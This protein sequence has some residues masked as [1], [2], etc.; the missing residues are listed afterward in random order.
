MIEPPADW[1][2]THY[3]PY[4]RT[5]IAQNHHFVV[6]PAPGV[7][8]ESLK[9][10]LEN[11]VP[12]ENITVYL[13][14][15]QEKYLLPDLEYFTSQGGRIKV[16]GLTTADRDAAMTRDSDYDILKFMTVEESKIFYGKAYY[17]RISNTEK[18]ERRRKGLLLHYN[19]A[20]DAQPLE[21]SAESE[22]VV[23]GL[24][25][26]VR[27]KTAIW[28]SAVTSLKNLTKKRDGL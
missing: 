11:G 24:P 26:E 14:H 23:V 1:L 20:F 28:A 16:E 17:P 5:A 4:F 7:D 22:A 18:N 25:Q 2:E 6:G 13:A 9:W 27:E 3:I 10:L 12:P 21:S 15:F 8:Q 19:P